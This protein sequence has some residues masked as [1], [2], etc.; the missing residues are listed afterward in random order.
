[1]TDT[2]TQQIRTHYRPRRAKPRMPA[3]LIYT[4]AALI[5][6]VGSAVLANYIIPPLEATTGSLPL[7]FITAFLIAALVSGGVAV[8]AEWVVRR[9]S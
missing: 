9:W 2:I 1:M 3:W 6:G 7:A 8:L 5:M 4:V